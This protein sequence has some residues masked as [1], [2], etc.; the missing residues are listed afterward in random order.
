[1]ALFE[2]PDNPALPQ[3]GQISVLGWPL[4]VGRQKSLPCL[5]IVIWL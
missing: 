4:K 3:T 2:Q 5:V 1:M